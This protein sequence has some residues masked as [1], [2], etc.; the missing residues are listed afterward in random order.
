MLHRHHHISVSHYVDYWNNTLL[1]STALCYIKHNIYWQLQICVGLPRSQSAAFH[2]SPLHT[3]SASSIL[4]VRIEPEQ[5]ILNVSQST[6]P[7][8]V[9]GGGAGSRS[10]SEDTLQPASGRRLGVS[11]HNDTSRLFR[12]VGFELVVVTAASATTT[13]PSNDDETEQTAE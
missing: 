4:I 7:V 3:R 11:T 5:S 12:F 10:S 6:G 13:L 1:H 8:V 2:A 9:R